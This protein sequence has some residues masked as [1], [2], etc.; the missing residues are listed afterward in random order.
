MEVLVFAQV[1]RAGFLSGCYFFLWFNKLTRAV[2][3]F[4][5][6]CYKPYKFYVDTLLLAGFYLIIMGVH[7]IMGLYRYF[8][9]NIS[10]DISSYNFHSVLFCCLCSEPFIIHV[11][12][13][14]W[15][16]IVVL[17]L[18]RIYKRKFY[19]VLLWTLFIVI[20]NFFHSAK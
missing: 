12:V 20:A 6:K 14:I 1:C 18:T 9:Q 16:N 5:F 3:L 2:A 13:F 19:Y 7:K 15:F 4:L 11:H 8:I 10:K 17:M